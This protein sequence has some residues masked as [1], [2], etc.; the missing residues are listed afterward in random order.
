MDGVG[1]R[2]LFRADLHAPAD[3]QRVRDGREA[4]GGGRRVGAQR[5]VREIHRQP[6]VRRRWRQGGDEREVVLEH[7][8]GDR[9]IAHALPEQVDADAV[10][11]LEQHLDGG[12]RVAA[13]PARDVA[14]SR[15]PR[16]RLAAGHALDGALQPLAGRQAKQDAPAEPHP[17][18]LAVDRAPRYSELPAGHRAWNRS[19]VAIAGATRRW[20][21]QSI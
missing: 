12:E 9:R 14:R 20:R 17:R 3:R 18:I 11:S 5:Q 19:C 4:I 13:R 1:E 10:A 21:D 6:D 16:G 2:G 15:T 8:V 7:L